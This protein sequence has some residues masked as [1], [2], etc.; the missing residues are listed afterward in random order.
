MTHGERSRTVINMSSNN[1][2][3]TARERARDAR[4]AQ[5]KREAAALA[6][7]ETF[8]KA[9][10]SLDEIQ[11]AYDKEVAALEK[12]YAG[13]RKPQEAKAAGAVALLNESGDNKPSIAAQLGITVPEVTSWIERSSVLAE[14]EPAEQAPKAAGKKA[15]TDSAPEEPVAEENAAGSSDTA[16]DVGPPGDLAEAQRVSA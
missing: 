8:F 6:A 3:L 7:V 2:K 9:T 11:A 10:D 16:E 13:R 4:L 15:A 12:K 14:S 5:Q 1:T